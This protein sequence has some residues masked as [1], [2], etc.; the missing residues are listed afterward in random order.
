MSDALRSGRRFRTFN[1]N[2]DFNR[3][4]MKIEIDTSL[5]RYGSA[6]HWT[7]WSNCVAPQGD[8]AWTTGRSC[9]ALALRQWAQQHGVTLIHIEPGK[10]TQ[11]CRYRTL[12]PH[13][14]H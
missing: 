5:P 2:D 10:P 11:K 4:S 13:F 12:Q 6:A 7:S 9:S 8:W 3:E 1:I 14:S